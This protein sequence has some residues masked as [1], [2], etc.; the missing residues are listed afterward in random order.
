MVMVTVMVMVVVVVVGVVLLCCGCYEVSESLFSL[1]YSKVRVVLYC[2]L[3]SCDAVN[4]AVVGDGFE[5]YNVTFDVVVVG[6]E[7]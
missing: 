5:T 7:D 1:H 2:N 6:A 4:L 3:I